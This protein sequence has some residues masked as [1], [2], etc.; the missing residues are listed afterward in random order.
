MTV[1][2]LA[3]VMSAN[4]RFPVAVHVM[5][6]LAW[7]D[8]ESLSSRRLAESVRT[9]PVV[10]RR[11]LSQLGRAGLVTSQVGKGGGVRL[12]RRAASIT[13]LDVYRAVEIGSPFVV[14]DK[15][16]NK[17]CEVSSSM[18]S[19]LASVLAETDRAMSRSLEK[20]RLSDLVGEVAAAHRR[21]A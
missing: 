2:I 11:L 12:A 14:P 18:K 3:T 13:L 21:P 19:I 6:A 20:V 5:T 16:E 7:N 4:T 10:I 9:N 1:T 8:G 15:P 17:A